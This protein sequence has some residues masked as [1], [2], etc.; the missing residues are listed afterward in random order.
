M[1][2]NSVVIY[3]LGTE[4][5]NVPADVLR[6]CVTMVVL[7]MTVHIKVEISVAAR[8]RSFT[9]ANVQSGIILALIGT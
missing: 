5:Q 6:R 1:A 9:V 3:F 7:C 8:G 4:S 2:N